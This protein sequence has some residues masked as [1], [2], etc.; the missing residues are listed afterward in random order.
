MISQY[1]HVISITVVYILHKRDSVNSLCVSIEL[2]E[3][4][5]R[6]PK[7]HSDVLHH[8]LRYKKVFN[9]LKRFNFIGTLSLFNAVL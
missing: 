2:L 8:L 5:H 9:D 3:M 7:R 1:I 6:I 4:E